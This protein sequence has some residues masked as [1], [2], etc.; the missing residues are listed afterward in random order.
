MRRCPQ[1]WRP[2]GTDALEV[3][4]AEQPPRLLLVRGR[5]HGHAHE[6]DLRR[7]APDA[8]Q[9]ALRVVEGPLRLLVAHGILGRVVWQH[10]VGQPRP[11]ARARAPDGVVRRRAEKRR[12]HAARAAL[13]GLVEPVLTG[14]LAGGCSLDALVLRNVRAA[15]RRLPRA[16][17]QAGVRVGLR[18][19]HGH[20]LRIPRRQLR[21]VDR[22]LVLVSHRLRPHHDLLADAQ[23]VEGVALVLA[24]VRAVEHGRGGHAPG[25]RHAARI[26]PASAR[27]VLVVAHGEVQEAHGLDQWALRHTLRAALDGRVVPRLSTTGAAGI[28]APVRIHRRRW[29]HL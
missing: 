15:R 13:L 19:D 27:R 24:P 6:L 18:D 22:L 12:V 10:G 17:G 20:E 2:L 25:I 9:D 28:I 21:G 4:R 14:A 1:G 16:L 11:C 5:E 29:P 3:A 26:R 8:H 7:L 23:V